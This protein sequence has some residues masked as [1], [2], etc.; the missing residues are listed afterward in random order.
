MGSC[1]HLT[2]DERDKEKKDVDSSL[3]FLNANKGKTGKKLL[4]VEA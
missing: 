4:T 1:W 2:P 3:S